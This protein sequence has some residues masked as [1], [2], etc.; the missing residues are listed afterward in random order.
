MAEVF[1]PTW[2]YGPNGE[3]VEV[4]TQA[5]HD[6]FTK[7]GWKDTP[8]AFGIETH[9][10]HPVQTVALVAEP[11]VPGSPAGLLLGQVQAQMGTLESDLVTLQAMVESLTNRLGALEELVTHPPAREPAREAGHASVPRAST[12]THEEASGESGRRRTN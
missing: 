8:A 9:P 2:L 6:R 4:H 5:D 12:T 1:S 3:G 10:Q 11:L 7:D